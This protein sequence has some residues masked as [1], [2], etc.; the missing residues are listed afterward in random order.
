MPRSA[1]L[2]ILLASLALGTAR[3]EEEPP[4]TPLDLGVSEGTGAALEQLDV[5]LTGPPEALRRVRPESFRLWVNRERVDRF[6]ADSVCEPAGEGP[7]VEGESG[8]EPVAARPRPGTW[9]LY[10]DQPHLTM[11]GRARAIQL[12]RDALPRILGPGDRASIVSSARTLVTV[13][14]MTG[15]VGVL[16]AALDRLKGDMSQFDTFASHED[17]RV[18]ELDITSDGPNAGVS[19]QRLIDRARQHARDEQWEMQRSVSRL[20][21]V[22]GRLAEADPPKAVLYFAD[23]ARRNPGE[24][25]VSMLG[26]SAVVQAGSI[27][28]PRTLEDRAALGIGG[29]LDFDRLIRQAAAM[30]I[31]FYA[32]ESQPLQDSSV[33]VKHA[34]ATLHVMAAETG[35]R[36]FVNGATTKRMVAGIRED[37]G[38]VWLLSFDPEGFP[39]DAALAVRVE[40]DV[41]GVKVRARGQTVI[42]SESKRVTSRLLAHFAVDTDPG[43][44]ALRAGLIPLAWKD[45][46]YSALLQVVAPPTALPS[47]TWDLGASVV[48][49]GKVAAETSGRTRV[50]GSGVPVVLERVVELSP[51]PYELVAVA[52]EETTDRIVS[53]HGEGRLPRPSDALAGVVAPVVLQ[54]AAGAFSRDGAVRKSG[55]VLHRPEDPLDPARPTALVALVCRSSMVKAPL[56]VERSLVG[57]SPVSFP[58]LELTLGDEPCGQVRDVIPERTLG[59]GGYRYVIRVLEKGI[60][61]AKSEI[62]FS[63]PEPPAASPAS[64]P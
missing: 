12:A 57:E 4:D 48:G 13:Q 24:H 34:Q 43:T 7:A 20:A 54:P 9:I 3:A 15:D 49:A 26:S 25:F 31:R 33:R 56:A 40:V 45:G 10:F 6:R 60:E 58:P 38:C 63:V 2:P 29:T 18:A 21:M 52:R 19:T 59:P 39:R 17:G 22:L 11:A 47:A 41:P 51:G 16:Q 14:P 64:G 44:S 28:D 55:S 62:G 5:T 32:V 35:G 46:A 8:T 27:Q 53:S 61:I 1:V 30:Q 50:C 37:L 23:T 42:Q 36:A